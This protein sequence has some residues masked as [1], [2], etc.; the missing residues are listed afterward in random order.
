MT[1]VESRHTV[2]AREFL[3]IVY[4]MYKLRYYL[5]AVQFEIICDHPILTF[6]HSTTYHNRRLKIWS[7]LL[8]QFSFQVTYCRGS[9]NFVADFLSRNPEEKLR[10]QKEE[11]YRIATSKTIVKNLSKNQ[12]EDDK[13]KIISEKIK[14]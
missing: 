7:L 11:V 14:K 9:D 4:T 5:I 3:A 10:D 13:L 12:Q 1:D 2:T 6:L 8:Q